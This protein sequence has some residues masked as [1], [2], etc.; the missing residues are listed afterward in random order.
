MGKLVRITTWI[1]TSLTYEEVRALV[2]L[3]EAQAVTILE[4]IDAKEYIKVRG[5]LH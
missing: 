2:D 3:S 5:L 1:L 4:L